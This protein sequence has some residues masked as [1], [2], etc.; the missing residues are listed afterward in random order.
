MCGICGFVMDGLEECP[1]CK[2]M[3]EETAREVEREREKL[4]ED[5]EEYLEGGEE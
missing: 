2:L 5:I 1:R 3:V 4:F